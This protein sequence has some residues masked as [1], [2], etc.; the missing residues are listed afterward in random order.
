[1]PEDK[2]KILDFGLACPVGCEDRS[3]FDGT[4][5]NMAPEQIECKPVDERTDIYSLGITAYEMV[6][7]AKPFPEKNVKTVM[8][9]HLH[10]GVPDPALITP[11]LSPNLRRFIMKACQRDPRERYRNLDQARVDLL[12]TL[13]NYSFASDLEASRDPVA[14]LESEHALIRRFIDLLTLAADQM[15]AGEGPP[16]EFFDRAVAFA[17]NFVGRFHHYKEEHILFT[18]LA[19]KQQGLFDGAIEAL[20]HQHEQGRNCINGISDALGGYALGDDIHTSQLLENLAAYIRLLRHHIHREDSRFFPMVR[21]SFSE[22]ELQG[23]GEL[24]A[25]EDNESGMETIEDNRRCIE[26]MAAFL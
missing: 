22:I 13:Q 23:L 14:I 17:R 2:I 12:P 1:M 21:E 4:I 26:G 6:T 11:G 25:H 20:R 8:D 10:M 18:R 24:L 7:G 19:E 15:E 16:R 3:I 5:T 9:K